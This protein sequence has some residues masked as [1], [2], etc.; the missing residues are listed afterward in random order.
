[1]FEL[2]VREDLAPNDRLPAEQYGFYQANLGIPYQNFEPDGLFG[3]VYRGR[4]LRPTW[5][6]RRAAGALSLLDRI[7]PR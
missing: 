4:R 6:Q 2:I 3:G 7:A 5:V 1:M